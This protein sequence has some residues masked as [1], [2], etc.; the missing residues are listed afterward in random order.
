MITKTSD[1]RREF[2]RYKVLKSLKNEPKRFK[3]LQK[4]AE[5][6]PAG[7]TTILKLLTSEKEIEP[8]FIDGKAGYK[9]IK[10]G[11]ISLG[12]YFTLSYEIDEIR[13]RGGKHF[14]DYSSLWGSI[15]STGLPW[16]IESDLTVDKEISTLNLLQPK[17]VAEIEELVFKKINDNIKKRK[18]NEEKFGKMVLG[19]SIDYYDLIESIKQKSL[20]YYNHMSKDEEKILSKIDGSPDSLTEKEFERFKKLRE[21][22]YEKIKNFKH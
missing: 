8:T 19:F 17:D 16:G 3:D 13:S 2:S 22:T 18:L 14:R 1:V 11:T 12:D 7:L 4:E 15:I 9:L 5:L 10:K 6:S 20:A 21:K